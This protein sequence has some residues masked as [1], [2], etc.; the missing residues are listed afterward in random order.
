MKKMKKGVAILFLI[1][2][3]FSFNGNTYGAINDTYQKGATVVEDD[4]ETKV[5]DSVILNALGSFVY[6]VAS[7]VENLVGKAFKGLTG[8]EMFP[9]ADR[10]L[11]N[12]VPMLDINIF[13]PAP[14]SLF[15][16][17]G[18]NSTV[19][20]IAKIIRRT[21]FTVLSISVA[22][23]TI[24]VGIAAT[25]LA[26]TS[27]ASEKAKYKEAVTKWLFSII[28]IFL[29]HNVIS[30]IFW[31]NEEMVKVASSLIDNA[32]LEGNLS[33]LQ[34]AL[35][36]PNE[37]MLNIFKKANKS[38]ISGV[39]KEET[40]YLEDNSDVGIMFLK[41]SDYKSSILFDALSSP[42]GW[43]EFWTGNGK[44]TLRALVKDI[45]IIKRRDYF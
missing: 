24:V 10:V 38:N 19:T 17:S 31:V 44:D 5:K 1:L 4:L 37:Q 8:T 43:T 32:V 23:L 28:L 42:S 27:I 22:F 20:P 30:F 12:A 25:K 18:E 33:L 40:Q 9:W 3:V 6:W 41:N 14:A 2:T 45:K 13:N 21:Y 34:E 26:L 36:I 29:M 15:K 11:F 7:A 35:D 39:T 16:T